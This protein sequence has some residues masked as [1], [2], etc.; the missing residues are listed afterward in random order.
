MPARVGAGRRVDRRAQLARGQDLRQAVEERAERRARAM[1]PSPPRR[2]GPCSGGSAPRRVRTRARSMRGSVGS[3]AAARLPAPPRRTRENASKS[4]SW[5]PANITAARDGRQRGARR[6]LDR[7]AMLPRMSRP[8]L[9]ALALGSRVGGRRLRPADERAL[10]AVG[11][12]SFREIDSQQA[13]ASR[14][15]RRAAA[16]GRAERRS[17]AQRVPGARMVAP[18]EPLP[19]RQAGAGS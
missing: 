5:R 2:G 7:G 15:G 17:P 8:A 3:R 10:A 19:T 4:S 1:R 12:P 16:P 18:E 11:R 13:S 14:D 9:L 6:A